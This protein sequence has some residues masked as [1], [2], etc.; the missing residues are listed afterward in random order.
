[1]AA[2]GHRARKKGD[3]P[4]RAADQPLLV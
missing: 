1:M 4:H 3:D 2:R